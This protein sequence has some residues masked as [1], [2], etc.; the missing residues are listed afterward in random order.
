MPRLGGDLH[1]DLV[2]QHLGAADHAGAIGAGLAQHRRRFTGHR[3]LVDGR[4]TTDD[5]AVGGNLLARRDDHVI[6]RTQLGR[7]NA[8]FGAAQRGLHPARDQILA[9]APQRCG[10]TAAARF[11][12]RF[13]EV[14][15]QHRH[16]QDRGHGPAKSGRC[17][18]GQR[19]HRRQQG[20]AHHHRHHRAADQVPRRQFEE[21][22]AQGRAERRAVHQRR[23]IPAG[24]F[25]VRNRRHGSALSARPAT[26]DPRSVP[27]PVRA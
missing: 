4:H 20:A 23:M 27:A 3:R 16:E 24:F 12:H 19:D 18:P 21:G 14:A 17:H 6:A 13:G 5:L 1:H 22:V 2:G 10:L 25:L 15:E 8:G 9:C 7:R 26:G 11:G